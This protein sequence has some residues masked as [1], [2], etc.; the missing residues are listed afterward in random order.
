MN[1]Q[2][3][4][5]LLQDYIARHSEAAFAELVR[6]HVDLVHSAALRMVRD[7]HLAEDISQSAF[8][9]LAKNASQLL[10]RPVLSGWLHR[11]AQNLAAKTVRTDV[12]RRAREQE[13]AAMNALHADPSD[14][15]WEQTE[16]HLDAALGEMGEPDRDALFLRYFE[17]KSAREMALTLG[18]SEDAAQKRV[19]RAVE[20]LRESLARRGVTIGAAGL[21]VAITANAVNAAPAGLGAAIAA[22]AFACT[23]VAATVGATAVKTVAMTALQKAFVTAVLIAAAGAAFYEARLNS[24]LRSQTQLFRQQLGQLSDQ[25]GKAA[26]E[27]D[28][29]TNRLASLSREIARLQRNQGELLRLRGEIGV[30]RQQMDSQ[31]LQAGQTAAPPKQIQ[32]TSSHAPGAYI[33]KDQLANFGYATPE[34]ALET[35]FWGMLHS[36]YDQVNEGLSPEELA[37]ELKNTK[38]RENFESNRNKFAQA[39]KGMQI[40]ARKP[41]GDDKTELKFKVDLDPAAN[42][43]DPLDSHQPEFMLQP[44]VRVDGAWKLGGST[45]EYTTT[46][47]QDGQVQPFVP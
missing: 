16:P 37:Q 2:T 47:E 20:R 22:G 5:Q 6:R 11:T 34:T 23:T 8:V 9:A 4:Q 14:A 3:D 7:D 15:T 40:V 25:I 32:N 44:M 27:R 38:G 42:S 18:T 24:T 29:A 13:A 19:T 35:I 41:L 10:D 1:S 26:L 39:F 17:R 33:A 46:W 45:R 36:T 12:R 30:M 21:V 31:R 43:L 28:D